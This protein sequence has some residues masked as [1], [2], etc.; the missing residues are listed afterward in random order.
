MR[1]MASARGR[2]V[3]RLSVGA[4]LL[5]GAAPA[6]AN[7]LAQVADVRQVWLPTVWAY[8]GPWVIPPATCLYTGGCAGWLWQDRPPLRRPVAPEPATFRDADIWG[9]AGSPWGYVRR[10][11]PP[12]PE[13][14]IQPR[15]RSASTLRPE[16][17]R[18]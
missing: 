17:A 9:S 18:D 2:W 8:P 12:T 6:A 10:L 7:G 3:A 1:A 16:Y 15:Y 13:S 14:Q 11:P 5:S 4:I